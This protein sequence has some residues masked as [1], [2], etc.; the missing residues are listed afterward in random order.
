M[1]CSARAVIRIRSCFLRMST[2]LNTTMNGTQNASC[3][4]PEA[5]IIGLTVTY[6]LLFLA[7]LTGNT[8]IGI[9]V[10]KTKTMRKPINFFIVNMAMSDLLYPIFLFPRTV[11]GFHLGWLIS[12]P[13]GQAL[14]K[15]AFFLPATSV[16]VSVQSLVLIAVDRFGAVVFPLRSPLI[17]SKLCFFFILASWIG[18]MAVQCPELF[19][20]K[21]VEHSDGLDC[22]H[23]RQWYEFFGES[24]SYEIYALA[25]LVVFIYVPLFVIALL[26]LPILVKLKTQ[27]IPG[28]QS[29]NGGEQRAKR[30][31]NVLKMSIAIVLVF[32]V[33]F[34]PLA[35]IWSVYLFSS[36]STVTLSCGLDYFES[37]S[38]LLFNANCAINPWICFIFS[39]NYRQGLKNLFR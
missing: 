10:Y 15:L 39:G 36:D 22:V 7:S 13:L 24:S 32:A 23:V 9:I 34:L 5:K 12:G 37:V 19:A 16:K 11:T 25:R 6:S 31:R 2:N 4:N 35:I 29:V 1:A 14:C 27:K 21:L 38:F 18:P 3:F 20:W 30:E 33:S 17:S 28:E 8:F 26:Y